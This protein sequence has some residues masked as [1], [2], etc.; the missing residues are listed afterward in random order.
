M[1]MLVEVK[2][3]TRVPGF[4]VE[5]GI[6]S[7]PYSSSSPST[8]TPVTHTTTSN[9]KRVEVPV[10]WTSEHYPYRGES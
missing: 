8:V 7:T 1:G 3:S 9:L 5:V 6:S 2:I 10:V 4:P